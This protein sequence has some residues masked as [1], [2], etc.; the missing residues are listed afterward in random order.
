MHTFKLALSDFT[1]PLNTSLED[2]IHMP[3]NH[4][5]QKRRKAAARKV[6]HSEGSVEPSGSKAAAKR[7][8]EEKHAS[9]VEITGADANAGQ[10]TSAKAAYS[11]IHEAQETLTKPEPQVQAAPVSPMKVFR[12]PGFGTMPNSMTMEHVCRLREQEQKDGVVPTSPTFMPNLNFSA[13]NWA[14]PSAGETPGAHQAP[15]SKEM[16]N[17]TK[18]MEQWTIFQN[19]AAS[20]PEHPLC[21]QESAAPPLSN[22]VE[23][24]SSRHK[25]VEEYRESRNAQPSKVEEAVQE[26]ANKSNDS[27]A[28]LSD[29]F[30]K[31]EAPAQDETEHNGAKRKWYKGFRR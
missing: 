19:M 17:L 26:E 4:N 25:E 28:S 10:S 14:K 11:K 7:G 16:R 21:K 27:L 3:Q 22:P 13:G 29:E 30:E 1:R 6:A 24:A 23:S 12:R 8:T 2:S 18:A 20:P 15:V 9:H 31:I 5:N